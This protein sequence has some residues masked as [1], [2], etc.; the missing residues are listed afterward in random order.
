MDNVRSIVGAFSQ[1]YQKTPQKLK[2]LDAFVLFAV[3]T[4]A[5]Q[6][7]YM[8]LVGSFPF[9][10]FLAGIFCAAGVGVLTISLRMQ[11]DRS[12]TDFSGLSPERA[13]ADYCLASIVLFMLVWNFMG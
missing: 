9:N 10:S 8:L 3:S 13:I 5:V 11:L 1:E 7:L 4:G 6:F 12:N 2:L